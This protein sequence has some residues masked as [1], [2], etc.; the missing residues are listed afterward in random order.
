VIWRQIVGS[1]DGE[2]K[3][4]AIRSGFGLAAAV[5]AGWVL[6]P[7]VAVVVVG[8]GFAAVVTAGV[9][10]VFATVTVV[11]A[12]CV[13]AAGSG[14]DVVACGVVVAAWVGALSVGLIL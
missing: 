7:V 2:L 5:V 6:V 11:G 8:G 12:G 1:R 13:A 9:T 14:V 4:S 3:S 10:G